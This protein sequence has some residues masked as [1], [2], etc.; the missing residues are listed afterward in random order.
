MASLTGVNEVVANTISLIDGNVVQNIDERFIKVGE[1][2]GGPKGDKGQIGL[3]GA[4]GTSATGI[5]G[6][7][8]HQGIQGLSGGSGPTGAKGDK[9]A[10]GSG[11]SISTADQTWITEG[12][13][14]LTQDNLGAATGGIT[15]LRFANDGYIRARNSSGT[16]ELFL[17]PRTNGNT[18]I[19][20]Y[21]SAGLQIKNNSDAT[22]IDVNNDGTTDFLNNIRIFKA[23]P[24][25][26]LGGLGP[27]DEPTIY[28]RTP[29]ASTT[30]MKTAIRAVGSNSNGRSQLGF[31]VSNDAGAAVHALNTDCSMLVDHEAVGINLPLGSTPEG[32]LDIRDGDIALSNYTD[33]DSDRVEM[34]R[35]RSKWKLSK[36]RSF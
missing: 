12:R 16:D 28:F 36:F 26:W 7:K 29:V 33:D 11:A 10:S 20:K 24:E 25:L 4:K 27:S 23:S 1:G 22:S 2:P 14:N 30:G 19:L 9:G 31:L 35:A 13:S 18:S 32:A 17:Y 15:A 3:K 8:G 34:V 21:G 5:K 6:E